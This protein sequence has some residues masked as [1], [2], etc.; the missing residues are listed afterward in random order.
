MQLAAASVL[1]PEDLLAPD[2]ATQRDLIQWA[3]DD[4]ARVHGQFDGS[5]LKYLAGRCIV[6][7]TNEAAHVINNAI[8]GELPGEERVVFSND[9]LLA[10]EASDEH[11]PVEFL[12]S[13][14]VAS[15]PPHALRLQRGCVLMVLRNY[16]PHKGVC[17]GTR[18]V[19]KDIGSRILTVVILTGPQQGSV[20]CLPR[21][22]CDSS[23]DAD[24]PF[25]FR[26]Y[27]FPVR[28]AWA[29]TINKSQGQTFHQ[30]VGV[31]LSRP[32]FAHGQLYVALSRATCK[33]HV[34]ILADPIA[35]KQ[36]IVWLQHGGRAL[37]TLNIVDKEFLALHASSVPA[38]LPAE[39][40]SPP[41]DTD[42]Y[43]L[44][45]E[46]CAATE[47][48]PAQDDN[49]AV[50]QPSPATYDAD[51]DLHSQVELQPPLTEQPTA[52]LEDGDDVLTVATEI[53]DDNVQC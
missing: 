33:E 22:C 25:S 5:A 45:W 40:V 3:Y 17:N 23:G 28:L 35:G 53:V 31:Y 37:R 15:M 20:V 19:L 27:Q 49:E 2:G 43:P 44:E 12:H 32:V 42:A 11:Y 9:A 41:R 47:A 39:S 24:L 1:L 4:L 21:I 50:C 46:R 38:E 6:T 30:R 26:R 36:Q 7:P 29:M 16:A 34:R 52:A 14:D 48:T 18:V 8:L 13:V 10:G 51:P